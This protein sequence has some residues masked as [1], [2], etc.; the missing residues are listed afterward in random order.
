[1]GQCSASCQSGIEVR[2]GPTPGFIFVHTVGTYTVQ[3]FCYV[4]Y[5]SL[6]GYCTYLRLFACM[7][8]LVLVT[9]CCSSC[10]SGTC[11]C[12]CVPVVCFFVGSE[13]GQEPDLC[14][15]AYQCRH[16]Y[17]TGSVVSGVNLSAGHMRC[18]HS[19]CMPISTFC[20][21]GAVEQA[22]FACCPDW[23]WL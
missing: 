10:G 23:L 9:W 22:C 11:V 7:S 12:V 20:G 8:G 13:F 6:H 3:V 2:G 19:A 17:T 14:V 16:R 1:M 18:C 4:V 5:V 15:A 21:G